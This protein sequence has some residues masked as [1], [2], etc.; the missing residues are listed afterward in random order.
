MLF[1]YSL[2]EEAHTSSCWYFLGWSTNDHTMKV[3]IKWSQWTSQIAFPRLLFRKLLVYTPVSLLT[4]VESWVRICYT[5]ADKVAYCLSRNAIKVFYCWYPNLIMFILIKRTY[6]NIELKEITWMPNFRK[7]YW[8]FF[9]WLHFWG[10]HCIRTE[11]CHFAV[12]LIA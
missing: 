8:R 10:S 1:I 4:F 11:N 2:G 5:V 7:F 3:Q 9:W 6:R 12:F